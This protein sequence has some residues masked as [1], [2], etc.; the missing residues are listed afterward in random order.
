MYCFGHFQYSKYIHDFLRIWTFSVN[1]KKR[2]TI[3]T[4]VQIV[5]YWC[6]RVQNPIVIFPRWIIFALP[7]EIFPN[8]TWVMWE[9]L[10]DMPPISNDIFWSQLILYLEVVIYLC[11]GKKSWLFD[12]SGKKT[13]PYHFNKNI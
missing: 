7:D 6:T 9:L 10:N 2:G 5:R 8:L 1:E 12:S 4:E 11:I 13:S 3:C